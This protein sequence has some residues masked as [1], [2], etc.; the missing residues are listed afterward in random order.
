MGETLHADLPLHRRPRSAGR[1]LCTGGSGTTGGRSQGPG[2]A[3]PPGPK[4]SGPRDFRPGRGFL[5]GTLRSACPRSPPDQEHVTSGG[6]GGLPV[7]VR[8]PAA[9][10]ALLLRLFWGLLGSGFPKLRTLRPRS[11]RGGPGPAARQAACWG[12]SRPNRKAAR[13]GAEAADQRKAEGA[14]FGVC[15]LALKAETPSPKIWA[16]LSAWSSV[17]FS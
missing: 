3:Q 11:L 7:G 9:W 8:L 1:T 16:V 12:L 17:L 10:G 5:P 13:K 2:A 14:G 6:T 4:G 15:A